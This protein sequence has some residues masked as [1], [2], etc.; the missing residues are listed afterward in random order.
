MQL[1]IKKGKPMTHNT[2]LPGQLWGKQGLNDCNQTHHTQHRTHGMIKKSRGTSSITA[3]VGVQLFGSSK[4]TWCCPPSFDWLFEVLWTPKK[5]LLSI[6]QSR[7]VTFYTIQLT[8]DR[9]TD[10]SDF[11]FGGGQAFPRVSWWSIQNLV[12]AASWFFEMTQ[13][14]PPYCHFIAY[15]ST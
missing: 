9:Q 12:G 14:L 11:F 6:C 1:Q 4:K 13:K 7:N 2:V 8:L 10:S 3:M 15:L 5:S